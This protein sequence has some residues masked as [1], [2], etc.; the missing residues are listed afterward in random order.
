MCFRFV[1]KLVLLSLVVCSAHADSPGIFSRFS[2]ESP[3]SEANI[4][5]TLM[6]DWVVV[7]TPQDNELHL[8]GSTLWLTGG[9]V[10][11]LGSTSVT[12]FA[13]VIDGEIT[14]G[15]QVA[16]PGETI[17]IEHTA[18]APVNIFPYDAAD[19]QERFKRLDALSL[20]DALTPVVAKQK[21]LKF[22]GLLR[23]TGVNLTNPFEAHFEE[24]R[25][26]YLGSPVLV[27]LKKQFPELTELTKHT[28]MLFLEALQS[29]DADTVADLLNPQNFLR[30]ESN[31]LYS[32]NEW[33]RL[34]KQYAK[35]LTSKQWVFDNHDM[36]FLDTEGGKARYR[37][38]TNG[39]PNII[40]LIVYESTIFVDSVMLER[41]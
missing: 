7:R 20:V 24:A 26:Q 25:Q 36:E 18:A 2:D 31:T 10:A 27:S 9:T 14:A 21:R 37:F 33:V 1:L 28:A 35:L 29:G 8:F 4:D 17:I 30:D 23:P 32:S 39:R 41:G 12:L 16:K 15:D 22:W 13:L 3:V 40:S 5:R 6:D 11:V 34:R 38:F 19:I